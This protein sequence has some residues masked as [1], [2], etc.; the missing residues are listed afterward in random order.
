MSQEVHIS[1]IIPVYNNASHLQECIDS[2]LAQTA[3]EMEFIFVENGSQ[4]KS[5]DILEKNKSNDKRIIVH[6]QENNGV[7]VARNTGIAIAKGNYIGFVDADDYV[8]PNYFEQLENILHTEDASI[9][10]TDFIGYKSKK[11]EVIPKQIS[12]EKNKIEADLMPRFLK[13]DSLNSVCNKLYR[14]KLIKKHKINFPIGITNGEDRDFNIWAFSK[15]NKIIYS[16]FEGYYYR[17]NPGSATQ[18][19]D[20][21]DYFKIALDVYR[22]D[23]SS[24]FNFGLEE[25]SKLKA[26]RLINTVSSLTYI[27]FHSQGKMSFMERYKNVRKMLHHESVQNALHQYWDILIKDQSKYNRFIL[28]NIRAKSVIKIYLASLYSKLRAI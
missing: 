16:P 20:K 19:I 9:V 6:S 1:V 4:D 3:D 10:F 12:Y 5:L 7:S 21:K 25:Y 2:L 26:I 28:K 17:Q 27:Y 15:A 24:F 13:E 23:T 11:E 14:S 22:D 18:N 8:K